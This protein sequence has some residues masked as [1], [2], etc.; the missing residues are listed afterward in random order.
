MN[1]SVTPK[2]K[3]FDLSEVEELKGLELTPDELQFLYEYVNNNFD[4]KAA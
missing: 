4:E 1:T 3:K 2:H